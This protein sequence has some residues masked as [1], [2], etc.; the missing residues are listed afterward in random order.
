ML[1]EYSNPVEGEHSFVDVVEAAAFGL[2]EIQRAF[3]N[4]PHDDQ[5]RVLFHEAYDELV[6]LSDM[7][8]KPH[9]LEEWY[10]EQAVYYKEIG[11]RQGLNQ[12][13]HIR[14]RI[15]YDRQKTMQPEQLRP[16]G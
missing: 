2:T 6:R 14:E 8:N 4:Y 12:A 16:S 10:K 13:L 11:N 5:L 7:H 3:D 9:R 1:E 15:I